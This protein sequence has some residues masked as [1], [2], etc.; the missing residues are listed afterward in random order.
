MTRKQLKKSTS[1]AKYYGR[2]LVE[3]TAESKKEVRV[4]IDPGVDG[5]VLIERELAG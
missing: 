3:E 2:V 5:E 4:L 1:Q